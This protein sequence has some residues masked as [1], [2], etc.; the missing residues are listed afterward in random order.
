MTEIQAIGGMENGRILSA[1][2]QGLYWGHWQPAIY[3]FNNGR[4]EGMQAPIM[5]R[6][7]GDAS[8]YNGRGEGHSPY[9]GRGEGMQSP[10][11]AGGEGMQSPIM[12][13]VIGDASPYFKLSR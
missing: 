9:N 12:A 1:I 8:P 7:I 11:M 5:A 13:R 3:K 4:G 2:R 10:I 6:V